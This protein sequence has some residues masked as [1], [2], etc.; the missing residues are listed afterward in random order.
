VTLPNISEEERCLVEKIRAKELDA[1]AE[2]LD[3]ATG[4]RT[5]AACDTDDT[6]A[7]VKEV[8]GEV[9]SILTSDASDECRSRIHPPVFPFSHVP[10]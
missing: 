7:E 9:A 3:A 8:L 6:V 10:R 2:M 1:I 4:V 5:R